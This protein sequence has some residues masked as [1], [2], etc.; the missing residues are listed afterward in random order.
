MSSDKDNCWNREGV[1]GDRSCERLREHV[2]CRNCDVWSE[3][4]ARVMQRPLP[5]DYRRAWAEH[6]S[7]AQ[8]ER[9]ETGL[10]SLVFRIGPEWLALPAELAVTVAEQA[11]VHRI[12]HRS[13]TVLRGLVSIRGQLY[14][15]FSLGAL[16]GIEAVPDG[17]EQARRAYPRLLAMRLHQQDCALPVDEVHGIHRHSQNE[18]HAPAAGSREL[19][20]YVNGILRF[21]DRVVGCLDPNLLGRHLAGLL[22]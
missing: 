4:S 10:A 2:H 13:G 6:F 16:L 20:H 11:P 1:G 18:L 22:K 17:H 8:Q 3:G 12:P 19:L 21:E 14:P 9:A 15:C 5:E 7:Q